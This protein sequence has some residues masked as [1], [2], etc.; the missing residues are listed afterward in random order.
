MAGAH[1]ALAAQVAD[2]PC[3]DAHLR[4]CAR[5]DHVADCQGYTPE[6]KRDQMGDREVE[7]EMAPI[8][9][10]VGCQQM[11]RAANESTTCLPGVEERDGRRS[12]A[13]RCLAERL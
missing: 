5:E 12:K 9:H 1:D 7:V 8:L 10:I 6:T 3:S 4:W 2:T 11:S 13:H